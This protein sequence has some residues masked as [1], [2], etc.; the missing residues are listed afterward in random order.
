[1]DL[2]NSFVFKRKRN[3]F[4]MNT[5]IDGALANKYLDCSHTT[6]TKLELLNNLSSISALYLYTG[7]PPLAYGA[8]AP[9]I[10]ET[11][12]RTKTFNHS[13]PK[14]YLDTPLGRTELQH[15]DEDPLAFPANEI[16]SNFVVPAMFQM[17]L[18]FLRKYQP[19]IDLIAESTIN[20]YLSKN[21]DLLTKGRQTCC[22]LTDKS[23]P[24]ATAFRNAYDFLE[25]NTNEQL[26]SGVEWIKATLSLYEKP[27]INGFKTVT[28]E[29]VISRYCKETKERRK[30]D[31]KITKQEPHVYSSP[32]EIHEYLIDIMTSFEGYLKSMERA[33]KDRRAIASPNMFLRMFLNIIED[34]HLEL[35]KVIEGSTISIRG[36]RKKMKISATLNGVSITST[37]N[38]KIIQGT[39][40]ATK[41]TE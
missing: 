38:P 34:F 41:W 15:W 16:H 12:N 36:E 25:S 5:L 27:S 33:H 3:S 37:P 10:A 9:K 18:E 1:M 19:S 31:T 7:V 13:N 35:G 2:D 14:V 23:I 39:E 29:R 8:A 11:V 26:F 6:I 24:A 17:C 32:E 20:F 30:T 4:L 28:R 22:P 40:D 21:A